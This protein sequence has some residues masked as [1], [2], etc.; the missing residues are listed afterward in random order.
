[1]FLTYYVHIVGIKKKLTFSWFY[2]DHNIRVYNIS[3][4][5]GE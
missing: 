2:D 1:M 5:I 3:T 4:L